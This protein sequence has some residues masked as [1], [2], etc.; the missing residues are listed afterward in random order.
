MGKKESTTIQWLDNMAFEP[1]TI[2]PFSLPA[3]I[4]S[5]PALFFVV[6]GKLIYRQKP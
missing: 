5:F 6:S 1:Y 2:P 4:K 3:G